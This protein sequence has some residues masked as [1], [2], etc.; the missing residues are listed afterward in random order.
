ME[1]KEGPKISSTNLGR[2]DFLERIAAAPFAMLIA[3][4]RGPSALATQQQSLF[5]QQQPPVTMDNAPNSRAFPF[6]SLNSWITPN[7]EFFVRS[8]FGIPKIETSRW[9]LEV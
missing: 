4:G 7:S 2:R 9:L 6:A 5:L 1:N 8:H 3:A